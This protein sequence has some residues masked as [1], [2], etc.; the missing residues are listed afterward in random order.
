MT[1]TN[2]SVGIV[3]AGLSGL[4]AAWLLEQQGVQSILLFEARD[5]V[6]GRILSVDASGVAVDQRFPATDRFD[7]GP[8]WFWPDFQPQLDQLIDELQLPRFAQH[9]DGD[10]LIERSP[11][12]SPVRMQGY[13]SSPNSMRL[14]G[15]T[16]SLVCALHN[17]LR[18]TRIQLGHAVSRLRREASHVEIITQDTAGHEKLWPVTHVFLALPPRLTDHRI[19]FD[20]PLPPELIQS[21]RAT[22]TWMAPHAKYLAIYETPFWRA[23][24]LSGAARSTVGPMVEIHDVSMPDGHAALFGFIGVP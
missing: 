17:R 13:A 7:L 5:T 18:H 21:W 15:G 6:G 4:V 19:E 8:T 16:G 23:Q 3:G 10:V 12:A 22:P 11:H 9:E 2:A 20:P 14:V 1:L 24:G